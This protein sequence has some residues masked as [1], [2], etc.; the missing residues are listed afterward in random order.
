MQAVWAGDR[1]YTP[2]HR[3]AVVATVATHAQRAATV[4]DLT[5]A[6]DHTYYIR[7]AGNAILVHNEDCLNPDEAAQ[8]IARHTRAPKSWAF[9]GQEFADYLSSVIR[10]GSG[11]IRRSL[12]NGRT[13]W[14][15]EGRRIIVIYNRYVPVKGTAFLRS[16]TEFL[17]LE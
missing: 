4:Y 6:T 13:A 8:L 1:L 9:S 11:A 17:G 10:S 16:F 14:W 3:L 2:D 5:V 12:D 7:A 15:D